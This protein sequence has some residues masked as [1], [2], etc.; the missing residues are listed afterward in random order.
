MMQEKKD[1]ISKKELIGQILVKRGF[2]TKEQ[3]QDALVKQKSE[4]VILGEVLVKM[5]YV[6]ERDVVVALIV[7]CGFPYLAVTKYSIDDGII[8]LI[9]EETARKYH[10]IAL[11]KV[12]NILSIVMSDPLNTT[13]ISE[14]EQLTKNKVATFIAARSEIDEAINKCY[15]KKK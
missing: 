15:A 12:G 8:R 10:I 13:V 2:I 11:D 5:G 14:I 7:Q 6:T 4:G 9:P 3:L 1:C